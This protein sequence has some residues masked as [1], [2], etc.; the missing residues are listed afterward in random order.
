[1]SGTP[2]Y[3]ELHCHSAYSF[4][5]GTS[6]P[7]ELA[8]RA[9]ELGH[10]ALALTDHNS[11]SGSMEMAQAAPQAGV[12]ALHGA[13]I[14]LDLRARQGRRRAACGRVG[15]QASQSRVAPT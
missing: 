14:D 15:R 1:M 8:L 7:E 11:V 5:D 2:P 6:L 3:I 13:E 9:A 4:L 12:R 10:V